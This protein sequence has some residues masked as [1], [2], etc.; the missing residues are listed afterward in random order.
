MVRLGL[1][2]VEGLSAV[3]VVV[4]AVLVMLLK[5][6]WKKINYNFKYV[7]IY[8]DIDHGILQ[9]NYLRGRCSGCCGGWSR[10]SIFRVARS[11]LL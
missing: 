4:V 2:V 6:K 5:T 8:R 11:A 7:D 3:V 9:Y 1:S 10:L